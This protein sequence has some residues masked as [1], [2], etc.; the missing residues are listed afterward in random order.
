MLTARGSLT[1][2]D[3][4]VAIH[5]VLVTARTGVPAVLWSGIVARPVSNDYSVV[6]GDTAL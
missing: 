5:R 4:G 6:T 3:E 2:T 1:W